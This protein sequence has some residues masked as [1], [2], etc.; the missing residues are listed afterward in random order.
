MNEL[1]Y[2]IKVGGLVV[3]LTYTYIGSYMY[4]KL[5]YL[6]ELDDSH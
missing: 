4:T 2:V 1:S 5:S 3:P 6:H